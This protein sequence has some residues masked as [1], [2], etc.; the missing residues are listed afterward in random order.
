MKPVSRQFSSSSEES[1]KPSGEKGVGCAAD[2][3]EQLVIRSA[4]TDLM[5]S[6]CVN[7]QDDAPIRSQ[8]GRT[9]VSDSE[10]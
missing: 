9:I 2:R 4:G 3:M 6:R 1:G 5:T 8:L 10:Y 7:V